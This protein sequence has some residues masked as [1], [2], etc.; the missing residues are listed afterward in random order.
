MPAKISKEKEEYIIQNYYN[1]TT[2]EIKEYTNLSISTIMNVLKR[3]G[4]K[5]KTSKVYSYDESY[6][7]NIDTEEKA[8]W[9]GFLY[10]DGYVRKRQRN[11]EMRLKLGIKDL[12]HLEKFKNAI[13][14]NSIIRIKEENRFAILS[15]NSIKFVEHLL[16]KGCHQAKTFTIKFPSFLKEDLKRHFIRGYFDGDGSISQ[17]SYIHKRKNR[18]DR[19]EKNQCVSLVSGSFDMLESIKKEIVEHC[20]TKTYKMYFDNNHTNYAFIR[21]W[22]IKDISSIYHYF[23][24]N[25]SIYLDRKKLKFEQILCLN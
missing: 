22:N 3:N 25:S 21:W 6:F 24:N 12:D 16:D 10:A 14:S 18:K 19:I 8:Y 4:M 5:N 2:K 11:S 23:Y 15:V 13:K 9:L 1:K 20:N 17:W 7:K